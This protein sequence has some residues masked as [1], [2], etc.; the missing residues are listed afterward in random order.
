MIA[1]ITEEKMPNCIV[2]NLEGKFT[3]G[4][5]TDV[6]VEKLNFYKD[7]APKFVIVNL[8]ETTFISSIVIGQFVKMYTEFNDAGGKIIYCNLNDM[9]KKVF[10]MIRVWDILNIEQDLESAI[11]KCK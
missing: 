3:G 1:N 6:L 10:K 7:S 8:A 11:L 9:I 2:L 4:E 5:E